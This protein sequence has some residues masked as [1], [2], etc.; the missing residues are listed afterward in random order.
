M[1]YIA[2]LR[3][4]NI[5]G[6]NVTMEKMRA[7]FAELGFDDVRS[8]IQTGNVFFETE[9]N[10][11]KLLTE[12]IERH[13]KKELGYGVPVCL[14]TIVEF[15]ETLTT[16][17]FAGKEPTTDERF[18]VV[19]APGEIAQD[20]ALPQLSPNGGQE[21]VGV[22]KREAFVVWHI[23]DGRPPSPGKFLDNLVG[24]NTTTRFYHTALKILAAAK[25]TP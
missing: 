11:E 25:Q 23:I 4:I 13:L 20:I 15:E 18:C 16:S 6:H 17:L 1:I 12:K 10:D 3:G 21:I 5:G 9:E 22:T 8:Y 14:R 7:L 2:L 24:P 19:F